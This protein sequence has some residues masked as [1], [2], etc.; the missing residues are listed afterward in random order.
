MCCRMCPETQP[1][2]PSH[3]L[4]LWFFRETGGFTFSNGK[5]ICCVV[6]E[7]LT[8]LQD[9]FCGTSVYSH[10]VLLHRAGVETSSICFYL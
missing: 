3:R 7:N 1:S 10:S 8:L 5:Q 4:V 2:S 6:F 9:A